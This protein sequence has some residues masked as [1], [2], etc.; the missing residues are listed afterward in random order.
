MSELGLKLRPP[1]TGV[2]SLAFV[3]AEPWDFVSDGPCSSVVSAG[4]SPRLLGHRDGV[5]VPRAQD[6]P[7]GSWVWG[8]LSSPSRWPHFLPQTGLSGARW[9]VWEW[10]GPGPS[11]ASSSCPR[12]ALVPG[13]LRWRPDSR[14]ARGHSVCVPIFPQRDLRWGLHIGP[15]DLTGHRGAQCNQDAGMARRGEW[16]DA[17][18]G[19]TSG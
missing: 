12:H 5:S 16:H 2:R 1:D 4:N 19:V 14:G 3:P 13:Q 7:S 10:L 18:W 11:Q 9:P 8:W 15:C 17:E 6:P